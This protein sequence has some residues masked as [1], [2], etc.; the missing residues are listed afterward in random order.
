MT[1]LLEIIIGLGLFVVLLAPPVALFAGIVAFL[2][3]IA[4]IP[5]FAPLTTTLV[6]GFFFWMAIREVRRKRRDNRDV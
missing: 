4:F 2:T 1:R 3:G 5:V 6:I